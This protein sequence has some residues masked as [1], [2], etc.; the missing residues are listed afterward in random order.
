VSDRYIF[1][2]SDLVA[3]AGG[4]AALRPNTLPASGSSVQGMEGVLLLAAALLSIGGM[5]RSKR[6]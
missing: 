2:P 5:L 4:E 3:L 1:T 6:G